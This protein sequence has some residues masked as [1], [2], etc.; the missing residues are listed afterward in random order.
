M[1]VQLEDIKTTISGDASS[2]VTATN[3][4][5]NATKRF[6]DTA[7]QASKSQEK[8]AEASKKGVSAL[9]GL[10]GAA[11]QSS[12]AFSA[13]AQAV[14]LT[15]L[16]V[17]GLA[18]ATGLGIAALGI[19]KLIEWSGVLKTSAEV[20]KEK[21]D[22]L[23]DLTKS[24][25][26]QVTQQLESIKAINTTSQAM[27]KARELED[28]L[29]QS[30]GNV[31]RTLA[32]R[33]KALSDSEKDFSNTGS[34][35]AYRE[36]ERTRKSI[37]AL[38]QQ[39]AEET[40]KVGEATKNV[41]AIQNQAKKNVDELTD[42]YKEQE[43]AIAAGLTA[44]EIAVNKLAQELKAAG[45]SEQERAKKI[46]DLSAAQIQLAETTKRVAA[47][48]E[49]RKQVEADLLKDFD[50]QLN[51]MRKL[52]DESK[53]MAES[54]RTP[55]EVFQDTVLKLQELSENGLSQTNLARGLKQAEEQFR[56]TAVEANKLQTEVK[57][58]DAAIAG[59][60]AARERTQSFLFNTQQQR[61][62]AIAAQPLG[63]GELEK[64]F[65]TEGE[66]DRAKFDRMID[67]LGSIKDKTSD[68]TTI[69]K[70]ANLG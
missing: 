45:V 14:E 33:R 65:K 9:G 13:A 29:N 19:G 8:L 26:D 32:E 40:A 5:S 59:S 60:R 43:K 23:D 27:V 3:T 62:A 50:D 58:V 25:K 16:S 11:G 66:K 41:A 64:I 4:A 1:S 68:T 52:E 61:Q 67:I 36:R 18:A 28:S 10:A 48:E 31:V 39:L 44:E 2:Y 47:E 51:A 7:K 12:P 17:K 63:T 20:A 35:T 56:K 42:A 15:T 24:A 69:I 30:I 55:F 34:I 54:L 49:K 21:K 57:N 46:L 37:I 22:K 53:S 38:E 6:E 70:P